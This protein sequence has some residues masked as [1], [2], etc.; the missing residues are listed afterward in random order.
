MSTAQ[1]SHVLL[2]IASLAMRLS[3][4]IVAWPALPVA[5]QQAI[6]AI[7]RAGRGSKISLLP[8]FSDGGSTSHPQV[9]QHVHAH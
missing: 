2:E 6:L 5:L 9:I 8:G 3:A 7:G 1:G 4:V